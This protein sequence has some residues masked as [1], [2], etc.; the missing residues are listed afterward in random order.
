MLTLSLDRLLEAGGG[1]HD[2]S[3]AARSA[4][5]TAGAQL[6]EARKLAHKLA[7]A[8]KAQGQERAFFSAVSTSLAL[9][10]TQTLT[11]TLTL[12]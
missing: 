4:L 11:L 9:T 6:K 2:L 12:I 7:S 5:N 8:R 10:L 1:G 3:H